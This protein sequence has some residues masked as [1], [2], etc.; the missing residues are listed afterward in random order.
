M[1][2]IRNDHK[3]NSKN[4]RVVCEM[5]SGIIGGYLVDYGDFC[6]GGYGV[7]EYVNWLLE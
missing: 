4:N 7:D 1:I 6:D 5:K 2:T 3:K